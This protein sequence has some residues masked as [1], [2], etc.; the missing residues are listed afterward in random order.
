[1]DV[2]ETNPINTLFE[3]AQLIRLEAIGFL[4]PSQHKKRKKQ[5]VMIGGKSVKLAL[6]KLGCFEGGKKSCG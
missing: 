1:M 2:K 5:A 3:C 6:H 4:E